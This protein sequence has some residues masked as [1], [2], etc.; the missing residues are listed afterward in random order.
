MCACRVV[1]GAA[2]T[3]TVGM[4]V[5]DRHRARC[6]SRRVAARESRWLRCAQRQGW[7]DGDVRGGS[8]V[9]TSTTT[10]C[11]PRCCCCGRCLRGPLVD[12]PNLLPSVL[13]P[14]PHCALRKPQRLANLFPAPEV[15]AVVVVERPLQ[16]LQL[17][18]EWEGTAGAKGGLMGHYSANA[19]SGENKC[20]RKRTRV[21]VSGRAAERSEARVCV[22]SEYSSAQDPY[23]ARSCPQRST[24]SDRADGYPPFVNAPSGQRPTAEGGGTNILS[25]SVSN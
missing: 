13:E 19:A 7:R 23:L 17:P 20:P 22:N 6:T 9:T 4:H 21:W 10:G 2:T 12:L 18:A 16:A 15:R 14:V 11:T 8:P 5:R 3:S 1:W 25:T 24:S